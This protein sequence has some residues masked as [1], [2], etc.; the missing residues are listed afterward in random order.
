M[1]VTLAFLLRSGSN[2]DATAAGC[3]NGLKEAEYW[4]RDTFARIAACVGWLNF[5]S[6]ESDVLYLVPGDDSYALTT[7][8]LL[9]Q[10]YHYLRS[11]A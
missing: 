3:C 5:A 1:L 10:N 2:S 9:S 11:L 4:K 8:D 7:E 6:V